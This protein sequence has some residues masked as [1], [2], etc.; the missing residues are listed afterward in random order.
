LNCDTHHI[1][2]KG[3]EY[4]VLVGL[5]NDSEPYEIFAG[6]NGTIDKSVKSGTI[7]KLKRGHYRVE[8]DDKTEMNSLN[9]HCSDEQEALTRMSSTALRH[10]ADIQ[11]IVHQLEKVKG[12]MHSFARSMSRTLKKYIKDDTKV[13]G[14]CCPTCNSENLVR[15]E[16]CKTCKDC[17]WTACL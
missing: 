6:K 2:V 17:A 15:Q 10:G 12:D 13:T 16:G 7:T 1:K 9:D 4:F 8:F 3:E 5:L 11:F 14:E